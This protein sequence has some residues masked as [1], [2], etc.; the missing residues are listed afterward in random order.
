LIVNLTSISRHSL[1]HD[2][3]LLDEH[4][5]QHEWAEIWNGE[6]YI[7]DEDRR[8]LEDD[9]DHDDNED[10]H[11]DDPDDLDSSSHDTNHHSDM[12]GPAVDI[13]YPVFSN[14]SEDRTI[15]AILGMTARWDSF[16]S[17]NLPPDPNGL[18]VVISNECDQ[19]FTFEIT[20]DEVIYLGPKDAHEPD[21]ASFKREFQLMAEKS[22]FT[23]ISM[24]QDYCPYKAAVYPSAQMRDEYK[25]NMPLLLTV[26]VVAIFMFTILVFFFYDFLVERRQTALADKANKSSAIVTALFPKIVRDRLFED[27]TKSGKGWGMKEFMTESNE[28][29]DFHQNVAKNAPIADLFTNTTVMFGDISGFTAWS[30]SRQPAEVFILLETLYGAFDKIAREMKVFKVETIGDCYVAATGLPNPQKD[31]HLRMVR[32]ARRALDKFIVLTREM[33]AT[34]GPDTANLG[35]RIGLHSGPVTAGVLRGEKSRFQLFGD[36]VNAVSFQCEA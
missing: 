18:I 25:S 13:W 26:G 5:D 20:G 32:F 27:N 33:Q 6:V 29:S 19:Q 36:T 28:D 1:R 16:L 15:V 14:L 12:E 11:D 4:F 21:Y 10:D 35:F 2:F 7:E 34:L 30:S 31:H 8:F 17:P 23:E 9:H 24:S 3:D 22:V